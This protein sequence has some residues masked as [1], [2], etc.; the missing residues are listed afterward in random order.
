MRMVLAV[1][2][3]LWIDAASRRWLLV[4]FAGVSLGLIGEG[5]IASSVPVERVFRPDPETRRIY[6]GVYAEFVK[7]HKIEAK[8]YS[9][10][11]KLR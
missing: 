5:D 1:M 4:L 7:L 10:L 11:A 6:D 3:D 9:R 8:M 2:I